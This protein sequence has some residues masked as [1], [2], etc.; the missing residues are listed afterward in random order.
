MKFSF[1]LVSRST[2][3]WIDLLTTLWDK[4]ISKNI[5][6]EDDLSFRS[7]KNKRNISHV[8][9][10]V[11]KMSLSLDIHFFSKPNLVLSAMYLVCKMHL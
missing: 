10:I 3:Y 7:E 6:W 4:H 11:E 9:Q 2:T 8:Y 5:N 1:K